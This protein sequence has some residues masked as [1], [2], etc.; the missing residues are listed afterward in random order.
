VLAVEPEIIEQYVRG[1]TVRLVFRDVLNHGEYSLRASE[2]AACA[3]Q[4]G[5]FWQMHALLF[6]EQAAVYAAGEGGLVDQMLA[7]GQRIPD[8]DL[9]AFA[10]CLDERATLPALQAADAEQRA[11]GIVFQPVFEA[12]S[13]AEARRLAGYQPIEVFAGVFAELTP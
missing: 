4:Q 5:R 3:G 1:G 2:A 9:T 8:L 13:G 6:Q 12:V 10:Q 7:F 11:R